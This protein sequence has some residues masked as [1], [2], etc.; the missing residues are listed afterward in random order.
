MLKMTFIIIKKIRNAAYIP[1]EI[2]SKTHTTK[3]LKSPAIKNENFLFNVNVC[4]IILP[5][6]PFS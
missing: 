4:Q 2:Y 5:T 1:F 6:D 3:D